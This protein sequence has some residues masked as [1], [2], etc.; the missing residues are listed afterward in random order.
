MITNQTLSTLI[1][2][3]NNAHLDFF[4]PVLKKNESLK[5]LDLSF[6]DYDFDAIQSLFKGLKKNKGLLE[7]NIK[8]MGIGQINV[9]KFCRVLNFNSHLQTIFLDLDLDEQDFDLIEKLEKSLLAN[10]SLSAIIS[11]KIPELIES[12]NGNKLRLKLFEKA[13][14]LLK[15]N[16]WL[17]INMGNLNEI[18]NISCEVKR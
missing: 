6:N 15:A 3:H 8:G 5:K 13:K 11:E 12:E 18:E 9:M 14:L 7:L 10:F 17:R 2:S 1:L 16:L 4:G